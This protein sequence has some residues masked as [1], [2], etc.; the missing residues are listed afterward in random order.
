[1]AVSVLNMQN[2]VYRRRRVVNRI[3]LTVSLG[4]L[5][6]GLFWLFWIIQTPV[7]YTHLDV[8]K[9]Q[10]DG[11]PAGQHVGALDLDA[12]QLR[13]DDAAGAHDAVPQF[14]QAGAGDAALG[15]AAFGEDGVQLS[16][17]HISST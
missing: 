6:F 10:H 4:T 8:Y 2:G 1:M 12:G 13:G 9:R 7:S 11:Q 5:V 3:M 15:H 16:L 17:I 14:A